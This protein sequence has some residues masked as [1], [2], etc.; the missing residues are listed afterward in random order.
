MMWRADGE[1]EAYMYVDNRV[2][3]SDYCADPRTVCDFDAGNSFQRGAFSFKRGQWNKIA[4]T[5][6]KSFFHRCLVL[7]CILFE[8]CVFYSLF[9]VF[10]VRINDVGKQNGLVQVDV[11]GENK[12][13]YE[14]VVYRTAAK[15][16]LDIDGLV[17]ATWFGGGDKSWAP[18][19]QQ[20]AYWK[21]FKIYKLD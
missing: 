16:D 6:K 2:Q 1:G 15:P 17:F 14:K 11:D 3:A 18:K 19:T 12:I 8:T 21:N 4:L 9:F 7:F 10:A 5:G 20:E 13:L